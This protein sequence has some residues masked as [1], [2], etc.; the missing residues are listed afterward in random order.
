M[1]HNFQGWEQQDDVCTRSTSVKAVTTSKE[2]FNEVPNIET[3]PKGYGNYIILLLM[4][5]CQFFSVSLLKCFSYI[6]RS[7]FHQYK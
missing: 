7:F 6:D 4:S 2:V 5:L 3:C 1:R